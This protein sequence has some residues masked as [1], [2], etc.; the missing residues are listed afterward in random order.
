M[1]PK[2]RT[3]PINPPYDFL[4][5][6]PCVLKIAKVTSVID[7]ITSATLQVQWPVKKFK[8]FKSKIPNMG[9]GKYFAIGIIILFFAVVI[10]SCNDAKEREYVQP[11]PEPIK[12]TPQVRT[13]PMSLEEKQYACK[14]AAEYVIYCTETGEADADT[15]GVIAAEKTARIYG[16]TDQQMGELADF[17]LENQDSI[18]PLIN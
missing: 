13:E 4:I 12:K 7:I 2:V 15:C 1:K 11:T 18:T 5:Y 9:L 8:Y 3:L 16:I 10:T 17:C 14:D 6:I